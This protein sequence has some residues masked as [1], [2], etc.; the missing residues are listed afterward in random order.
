[1]KVQITPALENHPGAYDIYV[2]LCSGWTPHRTAAFVSKRYGIAA[3]PA[4]II[5][6]ET[7]IPE[8]HKLSLSTLVAAV[9]D[10]D[11]VY[12]VPA[13]MVEMLMLVRQRI[14]ALQIVDADQKAPS[15]ELTGLIKTYFDLMGKYLKAMDLLGFIPNAKHTKEIR[16]P[17][18]ESDTLT[19]QEVLDE[20]PG[21]PAIQTLHPA[22]LQSG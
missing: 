11:V 13:E 15:R 9:Q 19:L 2:L 10:A 17:E 6:F 18:K 4:D 14:E 20:R 5:E 1:M 16:I 7:T 12:N 8:S 22:A 21:P 3:S